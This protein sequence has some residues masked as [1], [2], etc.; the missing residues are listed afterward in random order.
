HTTDPSKTVWIASGTH[1]IGVKF[2]NVPLICIEGYKFNDY[3]ADGIWDEDEPGLPGWTIVLEGVDALGNKVRIEMVT[4]ETGYFATCYR[5]LPGD[6]VLYE[7]KKDGWWVTTKDSYKIVIPPS[8]GMFC[9]PHKMTFVFGNFKLGK[10][11][12]YKYEDM[13]GN[14]LL[15]AGDRPIEG[16]TVWIELPWGGYG[17]TTT[18]E[19]GYYEFDG[20]A[21]GW[22]YVWEIIPSGWV[23][24]S[25]T[26]YWAEIKSGFVVELPPFLNVK[27]GCVY[28]YKF[29]DMNSNGVWDEDEPPIEGW[30]IYMI[31]DEDDTLFQTKTDEKG[32]YEFCGLFPDEFY[33]V[34]EEQREGWTPT[35][36]TWEIFSM[37][38]GDVHRVH[39]F[40]NFEN[41]WVCVFKY[42]DFA[43]NG[44]YDGED[45]PLGGWHFTVYGP[46][47]PY[48]LV[49]NSHGLACLEL[50]QAG[51]YAVVEE[52]LEGWCHTTPSTVYVDVVSGM[53][54]PSYIEFG[55]FKCV[56]V[57]FFKY[58]DVNSNGAY[59]EG[60]DRPLEGWEIVITVVSPMPASYSIFTGPDGTV[61]V[62]Y[63]A[64][65]FMWVTEV[66]PDGWCQL[67]P[68]TGY[69]AIGIISGKAINAFT[70][71]EQY[72][73]E[74]GNFECVELVVFKYWDK[75]S[76]GWYD[77]ELGDEP[78]AGWY[79]VVWRETETGDWELVAEGFTDDYG[80]FGVEL[81]RAGVYYIYE[82]DRSGWSWITP[83]E[84]Y[85]VVE[86]ASGM[87]QIRLEFGNY[88]HVKV[89][90]F[91]Y[92]DVNSNGVFDADDV[93]IEGWYFEMTR[94]GDPDTVY[95][96]YTDEYGMLV[97]EVNRS[98][99]YTIVEEDRA[100]WTHVNPANGMRVVNVVSGTEVPVQEFGNFKD[101]EII[102]CKV[103]DINA[104]GEPDE[105]EPLMPGW[106]F[107]LWVWDEQAEEWVPV[108]TK[109][110]GP[111]GCAVFVIKAAGLYAV[112]EDVKEGWTL[113]WPWWNFYEV[114]I[115][116][117]EVEK[118]FFSNFKLGKIFGWKWNDLDGDGVHDAN[119]PGL[120]GWTIWFEGTSQWGYL[121]GWTETD[122]N[123]YYEFTGLP[124]GTYR[125]WE[126]VELGWIAT[127]PQSVGGIS[128]IGHSEVE[129]DF[130]NFQL[131]CL[132]GYK[133]EDMDGDGVLDEGDNPLAGWTIYLAITG[134]TET[135]EGAIS[136][137]TII[138]STVTDESG[139]YEFCMLG[140][141]TYVVMEESR[142]G[143]IHTNADEETV[144]MTSGLVWQVHTFLNFELGSICGYKFEDMN[145]N[146]VWDE[147]E[148]PINGWAIYMIRDDEETVYKTWTDETGRFCFK[149]LTAEYYVVWEEEREGW[150]P[151]TLTGYIVTVR[152]GTHEELPPFG[153]FRCVDI[154]IF[155]FED[156]NGNGVFD[157]GDR[158]VEGWQFTVTGPLGPVLVKT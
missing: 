88:L 103:D 134:Y 110:T 24:T 25:P 143:W 82:E 21:A 1:V 76:N 70:Q 22:H 156:V 74:F 58:E 72:L 12:G 157:A 14:G 123:G 118:F 84:G 111:C 7:V 2:G 77:P 116:S 28:G 119:E 42:E 153:N 27:L 36:Q 140:P 63:C 102:V 133:Y 50:T 89:P 57:T 33:M 9:E 40:G 87:D 30:T 135:P 44:V 59:D 96:G 131:G 154:P 17:W 37:S 90:I 158:P 55:N 11:C 147:N 20:L 85:Y 43:S 144:V 108:E 16:W 125:V 91:K 121:S 81:C 152:S 99:L 146:G 61:T 122:E 148:P 34:W 41:V 141:G 67:T 113:I 38:S 150:C 65:V 109:E 6:Y 23:P 39:D 83:P 56:E 106:S 32:Y 64:S 115:T 69:Y 3:D 8:Q 120:P 73:Y 130:L 60:T 18:D 114:E 66:L 46:G 138:D 126:L 45:I 31:W 78:L 145:S 48:Y 100:G 128:I 129:V 117:G 26:G 86:V 35:T 53:A 51:Q 49:T 127:S 136:F 54:D 149:G 98:G 107:T 124:L 139:Y 142:A 10:I 19:N 68:A 95:S 105:G 4:D 93:P 132:W 52:D 92:E 79:I 80:L 62:R 5:V 155:K 75:C 137:I 151:T 101:A 97:F 94:A 29:E 71:Q 47:G 112:S 104:N 15:D 13:N